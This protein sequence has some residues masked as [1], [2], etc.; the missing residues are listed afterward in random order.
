MLKYFKLVSLI[1]LAAFLGAI[2]IQAAETGNVTATVTAQN[3][4]V[5][6]TDGSVSYGVISVSD[7]QDTT[8][9]GVNDSQTATNDGN[10]TED[11]NVRGFDTTGWTLGSSA[12]SE[13]YT[14]KFCTSNCDSSPT[15]TALTTSYQTLAEDVVATS[16]TQVFDLQIGTPTSTSAYTQQTATVTVQAVS[17]S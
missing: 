14:H 4:S 10:I 3:I 17:A 11:F 6:V 9:G 8:T 15:W 2:S 7:T 13:T 16:G 1:V 12:G 5:A